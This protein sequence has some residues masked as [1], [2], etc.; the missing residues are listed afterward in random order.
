MNSPLKAFK[1]TEPAILVPVRKKTNVVSFKSGT[2]RLIKS[3]SASP[4]AVAL[5]DF[6]HRS[7]NRDS[8]IIDSLFIV[9]LSVLVHT[10]VVDYFKHSEL[11]EEQVETVKV[12]SKVQISFVRPQPKPVI[13]PPPPPPPKVVALKKPPKPK[14]T[15]KPRHLSWSNRLLFS[16]QIL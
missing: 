14:M 1:N 15:P 8:K 7:D 3:F 11:E 13:Q 9:I 2:S 5:G 16:R 6:K 12:P 10:A 4:V